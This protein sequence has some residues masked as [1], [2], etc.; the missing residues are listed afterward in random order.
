MENE[1]YLLSVVKIQHYFL[2]CFWGRFFGGAFLECFNCVEVAATQ[3]LHVY[4]IAPSITAKSQ[5]S[6]LTLIRSRENCSIMSFT[7]FQFFA[8]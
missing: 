6:S 4:S 8:R 5:K 2:E 1:N 7:L 3:L